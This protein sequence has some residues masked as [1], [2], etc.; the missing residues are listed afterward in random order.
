[1]TTVSKANGLSSAPPSPNLATKPPKSIHHAS[2]LPEIRSTLAQLSTREATIT[3]RLDHLLNTHHDLTHQLHRLDLLRAHLATHAQTTRSI[4]QSSLAPAASTALRLSTAVSTLDTEQ[5]AVRSTLRVVEQVVELRACVLGVVGCMGAPQDWE[6]AASYLQRARAIPDEVVRGAFAEM[7]V[8]TAEV[9]DSP[10]TTLDSAAESLCAL[11]LREF[12]RAAGT[13]DGGAVTRFFKLFPMIGRT[14]TGLDAYGRYVCQGVAARARGN[15]REGVGGK[16]R[17]FYAQTLTKLFE[18]VAQIVDGHEPL[19]ERHY[20]GGMMVKVIERLQLEADIQGGLILD[21]WVDERSVERKMTEV[22]SY[23]FSFLVQSFLSAPRGSVGTPRA[24]SPAIRDGTTASRDA[25]DESVDMKEVD[26]LLIEIA[27]MLGRWALYTRFLASK[28]TS[29]EDA[30]HPASKGLTIPAFLANSTLYKKVFKSLIDPFNV[31]TTFYFRRSVEKSFQMDEPPPDLSL[32]PSKDIGNPPFITSAVD[33]V[34]YI[35][36]QVLQRSLSTSQR[37]VV[38]SVIPAVERVLGSDF[39]GMTQRKMQYESYPK[40]AIQGALPPEDKI[41]QF[42]VLINNLDVATDYIKRIIRT[43]IGFSNA[44]T[45][46]NGA[47]SPSDS[48]KLA[49]LFPFGNDA[50]FVENSL[51]N[52][53]SSF[54]NKTS[55]LIAE[56]ILVTFSQ[57]MKPR[58]RPILVETFRDTDYSIT[59]EDLAELRREREGDTGGDDDILNDDQ[60]KQRFTRGWVALSKPLKRILTERNGDRLMATAVQYLSRA[61]EKRIWSYY[62]RVNELGAVRMERDIAGIVSA[63][64]QG[65]KYSLRDAFSRCVQI[66]LVMNME[67]DEWEEM[68]QA[69]DAEIQNEDGIVWYLDMDE[70]KR[71]RAIVKDRG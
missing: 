54:E 9:P 66:T 19:V 53:E 34:M 48:R 43:H 41:L 33:D 7:M 5:S 28:A 44:D 57:V 59:A 38:S 3:S 27:F 42:L 8:P 37:S 2:T 58:M 31:L 49:E 52:V 11:F 6:G 32:S 55:E 69:K 14:G 39:V 60:V 45:S 30:N 50:T 21:T 4:A 17:L 67:E 56:A 29:E 22:K 12:E 51:K 46:T 64:V 15:L 1:M 24:M 63:A 61:L 65:G 62:G 13:G 18:H 25:E 70:R 71:A 40:A 20:G 36:N 68:V 47:P 23:A 26:G 35:V 10:S 16:E